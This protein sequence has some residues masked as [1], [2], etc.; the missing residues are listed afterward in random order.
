M[1]MA[2]VPGRSMHATPLTSTNRAYWARS[3]C[4]MS[5]N[6]A[7]AARARAMSLCGAPLELPAAAATVATDPAM[8]T[9]A[10]TAASFCQPRQ[11]RGLIHPVPIIGSSPSIVCV[12]LASRRRREE[13]E[14][15]AVGIA[16]AQARAV[17]RVLDSAMGDAELVEL[18]RP[19]LQLGAVS[20]AKAQVVESHGELAERRGRRRAGV[21]ME[22]EHRPV[23]EQVHRVVERRF[24]VL[25][26][27]RLGVEQGLVPGN[28]DRQVAHGQSYVLDGREI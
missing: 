24:G 3:A 18:A 25:V 2:P 22:P 20:A 4:G 9:T 1:P 16:E 12:R 19:L 10:A 23:A 21:L 28:A 26:E 8:T 27:H 6:R 15:D 17:A 5:W 14:G 11:R 13:L 7:E